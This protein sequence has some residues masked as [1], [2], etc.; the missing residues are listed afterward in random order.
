MEHEPMHELNLFRN[1][2]IFLA[3]AIIFGSRFITGK[4]KAVA[5]GLAFPIKP[6]LFWARLLLIP[7]YIFGIWTMTH[8]E[9]RTLPWWAGALFL[10]LIVSIVIRLPGTITLTPTAIRQTFW[11]LPSKQIAY[12]DVMAL[13]SYAGARMLRVMGNNR[14][15]ITHTQNHSAPEQ[16]RTEIESHTGKRTV[17]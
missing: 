2:F 8:T 10:A 17:I 14:T 13:Q 11:L 6:L 15:T 16:F 5:D 1:V 9:G 4:P 12:P 7:A 3:L